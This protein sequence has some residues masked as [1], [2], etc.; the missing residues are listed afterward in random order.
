MMAKVFLLDWMIVSSPDSH[1]EV[2]APSVMALGDGAAG[3]RFSQ[4]GETPLDGMSTPLK[5]DSTEIHHPFLYVRNQ[6]KIGH[7]KP[8][9]RLS[10]ESMLAPWP[11][12]SSL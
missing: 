7:L 10:P 8:G 11:H 4:K 5:R 6:G 3:R 2:L 12:A 9:M 1:G